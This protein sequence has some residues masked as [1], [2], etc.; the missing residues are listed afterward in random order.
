MPLDPQTLRFSW[1]WSWSCRKCHQ[2]F[3]CNVKI[4]ETTHTL[5]MTEHC[6]DR[7]SQNILRQLWCNNTP[8]LRV[9]TI[10][11]A[12]Q[13]HSWAAPAQNKAGIVHFV[14]LLIPSHLTK[15]PIDRQI[16]QGKTYLARFCERCKE[17]AVLFLFPTSFIARNLEDRFKKVKT[18]GW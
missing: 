2:F 1:A 9:T 3:P 5:L 12:K 10:V 17:T 18:C 11:N 13:M 8:T 16:N 14:S 15:R 6:G 7:K 4:Q